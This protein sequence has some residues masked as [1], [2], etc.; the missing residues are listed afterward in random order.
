MFTASVDQSN[1]NEIII[2][3]SSGA[4]IN[5]E[6][7]SQSTALQMVNT[8]SNGASWV[9]LDGSNG[10]PNYTGFLTLNSLAEGVY[11]YTISSVDVNNCS[12][13]ATPNTIQQIITVENENILEIRE[14]PIVDEYLCSGK[15]GTL[16]IDVFDGNTGPLTFFYNSAPVTFEVVGS[17]QY[18]INIDN[19]V[20]SAKLE[21]FNN[22]NCGLSREINVGNGTPLFDF[23]SV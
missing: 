4:A 13:G 12:N 6:V 16:F 11:R 3:S 19:P 7:V 5:L 2:L 1:P 8:S 23:N 17:N 14:G 15:S 10:N 22:A 20:E 18:L 9:A 21:I